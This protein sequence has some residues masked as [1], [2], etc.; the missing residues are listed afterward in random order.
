M[1]PFRISQV[2]QSITDLGRVSGMNLQSSLAI[3]YGRYRKPRN[4]SDEHVEYVSPPSNLRKSIR[5]LSTCLDLIFL[6]VDVGMEDDL[7]HRTL[8]GRWVRRGP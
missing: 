3:S 6:S 5:K 7:R 8:A 2:T 4:F 1:A